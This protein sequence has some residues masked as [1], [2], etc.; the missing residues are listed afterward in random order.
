[1]TPILSICIPSFGRLDITRH[2]IQS[3]YADLSG[4]DI[5]EFEVL[6]S[7]NDPENSSKIFQ[8]EFL[9]SNFHYYSTKCDGFMNSFY[10]LTYGNGAYLK[11]LNNYT[12][13]R[14]HTLRFLINEIKYYLDTKPLFFFTDGFLGKNSKNE[15]DDFNTYMYDLSYFSSWST[16]FGIWKDDFEKSKSIEKSKMFPHTSLFLYNYKK[17]LFVLND[18]VLFN[19]QK[20]IKK[21][22]YN[23]YEVFG[24]YYLDL[25]CLMCRENRISYKTF[26]KIKKDLLLK[27]LA[28]RYF[29]TVIAKMDNF[30]CSKIKD[31]LSVYYGNIDYYKMITFSLFTPISIVYKKIICKL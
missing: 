27:Y 18:M 19:N 3:I 22:G 16:G 13:F 12:Q 4:V 6:I 10:S 14:P 2:T 11:L 26:R 30:E 21:G 25:I 15:Y 7:D 24:I 1:M 20:I 5:N 23:P 8:N 29:K 31:Y 28:T 17:S 9:Y